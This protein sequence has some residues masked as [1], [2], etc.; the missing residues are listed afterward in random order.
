MDGTLSAVEPRMRRAVRAF[1]FLRFGELLA[2]WLGTVA[3]LALAL[4]LLMW[5]DRVTHPIVVAF[6]VVGILLASLVA[7]VVVAALAAAASRPRFWLAHRLERVHPGLLDR[8]N[9]L[10]FLEPERY[11]A[12]RAAVLPEDRGADV[13]GAP[14]RAVPLALLPPAASLEMGRRRPPSRSRRSRSTPATSHGRTSASRTTRWSQA[15]PDSPVEEAAEK[16]PA[17]RRRG[18]AAVGRGAH[19]RARAA[20]CASPRSTWCRSRS[21]PRPTGRSSRR[22]G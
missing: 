12:D 11:A 14:G 18:P 19:H 8:L 17:G 10:V 21:R 9:T 1:R 13:R 16:P 7:L 6:T 4:G 20:T 2:W 3:A 22:C 15:A 5:R